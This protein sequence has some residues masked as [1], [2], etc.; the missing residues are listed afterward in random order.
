MF[1]TVDNQCAVP[2]G[3]AV[4]AEGGYWC[5]LHGASRL[6]RYSAD[7]EVSREIDLPVSQPTMC[8]FAGRDLDELY[9]TSASDKLSKEQRAREPNAGAVLRLKP[10]VRGITRP[11]LVR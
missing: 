9:V 3:A 4:D 1:A 6:R 11:Y 10:G 5:A 2:D 7:G 8:A